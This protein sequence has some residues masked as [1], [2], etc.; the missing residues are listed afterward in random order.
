[1]VE[2]TGTSFSPVSPRE[3]LEA[4]SHLR[5]TP[6]CANTVNNVAATI[7]AFMCAS[8]KTIANRRNPVRRADALKTG[9]ES[10]LDY[11]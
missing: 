4:T 1:V 11:A 7:I 5:E 3:D 2:I 8:W 6:P 9:P 10:V